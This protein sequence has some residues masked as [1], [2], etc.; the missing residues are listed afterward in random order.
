[1]RGIV[2]DAPVRGLL[3]RRVAVSALHPGARGAG[4]GPVAR[5]GGPAR[6][7]GPGEPGGSG[8]LGRVGPTGGEGRLGLCRARCP[9]CRDARDRGRH[10]DEDAAPAGCRTASLASR[11]THRPAPPTPPIDRTAHPAGR[12]S[13]GGST[14]MQGIEADTPVR[15]P[16]PRGVAPQP[17]HRGPRR[18]RLTV[19]P[20][21][22]GRDRGAQI[23]DDL[24]SARRGRVTVKRCASRDRSSPR[25]NSAPTA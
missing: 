22:G 24:P 16:L 3:A 8:L 2:R 1:M 11:N 18:T 19:P 10:P 14:R 25:G 17:L 5:V 7:A 15:M 9:P 12:L 6:R 21:L 13:G 4:G 20:R 23:V